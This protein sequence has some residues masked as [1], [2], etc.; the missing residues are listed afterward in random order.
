MPKDIHYSWSLQHPPQEVWRYLTDPAL[1]KQ[2]LMENDFQPRVGHEFMFR[3][4][5]RIKLGFDGNIFCKVLVVD[6]PN[7]LSYSWRG[8]PGN[9]K[10]TL[11]SVVTWTLVPDAG[12]T[13]LT[14]AHTGFAPFKNFLG[15]LTMKAGW[16]GPIIKRLKKLLD[17]ADG[18]RLNPA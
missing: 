14:L 9:G 12:G 1:L 3:A 10:I 16:G 5:P 8:G 7:R 15:H 4:R 11:D 17:A 2:W 13:R 18:A 6:Q